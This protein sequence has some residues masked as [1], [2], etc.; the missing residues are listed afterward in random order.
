MIRCATCSVGETRS[1]GAAVASVAAPG[2]LISLSGDLGTGKTAFVQGFAVASGVAQ[3][4]TSPTFVLANRYEGRIVVNHLDAYRLS[5]VGEAHDLALPELL[6]DG[7]TLV[8]WGDAISA[9]LPADRLEIAIGFGVGP[10][11]RSVDL[12]ARGPSWLERSAALDRA[13]EA[14]GVP[15]VAADA[16]A[17]PESAR[18]AGSAAEQVPVGAAGSAAEPESARPAGPTTVPEPAC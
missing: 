4:V 8:E 3:P 1:L 6:D 17:E 5:G 11:D 14:W 13:V 12:T 10:D 2:D 7:V 15:V 18:A 9:A 16:S